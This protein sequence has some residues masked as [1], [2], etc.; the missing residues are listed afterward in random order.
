MLIINCEFYFEIKQTKTK[1][2]I[3]RFQLNMLI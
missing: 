1:Q 3:L 2:K